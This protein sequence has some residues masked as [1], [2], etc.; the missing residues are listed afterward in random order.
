M[1]KVHKKLKASSIA[2]PPP[3]VELPAE[4][5]MDILQRLGTIEI[6]ESVQRVCSTWWKVSHDP[7]MWHV[8]HLKFEP[9][10]NQSRH[11]MLEK[12]C[13]IAVD[14]SQGQLLEI[15]IQNFGSKDLLNYIYS[16]ISSQL[17]HIRLVKCGNVA[18]SLTV[19]AKNFPLLEE[20][21]THLTLITEEDIE[22]VGRYCPLLKSFTLNA[23]KCTTIGYSL[24]PDDCQAL[25]ISR[26]MPEL[27][28]LA[29]ILNPLTEVGLQAILDG[30]PHLVSLDLRRCN[31]DLEGDLETRC[32]QQIVDL[33]QPHASCQ[34]YE[35][36]SEVCYYIYYSSSDDYEDDYDIWLYR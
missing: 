32:R 22:S 4:I 24:S 31:I 30:C 12:I 5:T 33:K 9:G 3:W 10:S 27:W 14:R 6:V 18:G 28:H 35:F 1:V 8:V 15:S 17:R 23:S 13:R 20:L 19:A 21:H 36:D 2:P 11:R 25:A 26:S 7:T 16:F 34:D 29:L